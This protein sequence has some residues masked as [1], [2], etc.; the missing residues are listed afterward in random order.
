M[1]QV[2]N[3]LGV[4]DAYELKSSLNYKIGTRSGPMTGKR[5]QNVCNFLFTGDVKVAR[6]SKLGGTKT[7]ASKKN[8]LNQ[9][10][11]KLQAQK[12]LNHTTNFS[13]EWYDVGNAVECTRARRTVQQQLIPGTALLNQAQ[14]LKR[15]ESENLVSINSHLIQT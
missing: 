10:G 6:F 14:I 3:I 8:A 1:N 5:R 15:P 13:G 7:S 4:L 11:K 9:S 12:I 2:G